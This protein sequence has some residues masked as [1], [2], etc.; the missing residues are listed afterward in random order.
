[1]I[2]A[3]IIGTL[4]LCSALNHFCFVIPKRKAQYYLSLPKKSYSN[5]KILPGELKVSNNL[6]VNDTFLFPQWGDMSGK[7]AFV[8]VDE[9]EPLISSKNYFAK[10]STVEIYGHSYQSDWAPPER[11][12]CDLNKDKSNIVTQL[13]DISSDGSELYELYCE[14][15]YC[16]REYLILRYKESN[17]IKAVIVSNDNGIN[18]HSSVDYIREL[19]SKGSNKGCYGSVV[20]D[21][22]DPGFDYP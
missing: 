2:F 9:I 7:W 19:I 11:Y 17:Q 3:V 14:A 15:G 1:M 22:S 4:I 8:N 18:K 12:F 6:Q 13:I 5:S 16:I 21:W 10:I 20:N